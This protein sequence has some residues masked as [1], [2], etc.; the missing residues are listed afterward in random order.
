M[1]DTVIKAARDIIKAFTSN[2]T[3]D[4][5]RQNHETLIPTSYIHF[6]L[7]I[8]QTWLI[9]LKRDWEVRPE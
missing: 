8:L 4:Y 1:P 6:I 9:V 7:A 5:T 3:L 2:L